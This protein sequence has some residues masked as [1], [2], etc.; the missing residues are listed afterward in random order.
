MTLW[1]VSQHCT[2]FPIVRVHLRARPCYTT[3]TRL[4]QNVAH[5]AWQVGF[6]LPCHWGVNVYDV[7]SDALTCYKFDYQFSTHNHSTIHYGDRL[8]CVVQD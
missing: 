4:P 7:F 6:L 8:V 2:N 1:A 5:K 3:M